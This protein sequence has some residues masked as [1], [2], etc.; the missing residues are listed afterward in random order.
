MSI[1]ERRYSLTCNASLKLG[2]ASQPDEI[3]LEGLNLQDGKSNQRCHD[4]IQFG[5]DAHHSDQVNLYSM[6]IDKVAIGIHA[7]TY[8]RKLT[9][10]NSVHFNDVPGS[11]LFAPSELEHE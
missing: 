5:P 9:P 6:N 10:L 3:K 7:V 1:E 4:H 2:S 11:F 8:R